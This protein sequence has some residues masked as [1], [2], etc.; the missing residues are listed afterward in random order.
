MKI[1]RKKEGLTPPRLKNLGL[2]TDE[3]RGAF[4]DLIGFCFVIGSGN[5]GR[6]VRN[7]RCVFDEKTVVNRKKDRKMKKVG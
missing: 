3:G 6:Q 4:R 7:S 5:D 1:L 2:D